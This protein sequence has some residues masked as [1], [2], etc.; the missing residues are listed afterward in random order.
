MFFYN[1]GFYIICK[2]KDLKRHLQTLGAPDTKIKTL[3]RLNLN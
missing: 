1:N 2:A 3:I